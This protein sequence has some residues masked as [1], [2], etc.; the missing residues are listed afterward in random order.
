MTSIAL[1]WLLPRLSS[2]CGS[3]DHLQ[4]RLSSATG[5]EPFTEETMRFC[6]ALG[7][8]L[9]PYASGNP[10]LAA[11]AFWLR[12][13]HVEEM[14]RDLPQRPRAVVSGRG[15]VFHITPANV[16]TMFAYSL[17]VSLLAGNANVIRLSE[18]HGPD[19]ETILR[20]LADVLSTG[21]YPQVEAGTT[22]VRFGHD[23]EVMAAISRH[24]DVRVI[25]GGDRTIQRVRMVPLPAHA[26]EVTFADRES[27]T[28]LGAA[29]YESA[30]DVERD[31]VARLLANDLYAFDQMGCASP[32]R[33]VW[34]RETSDRGTVPAGR[35]ASLD[36]DLLTRL[37]AQAQPRGYVA[38][39]ATTIAKMGA[40]AGAAADGACDSVAWPSNELVVVRAP[41]PLPAPAEF[42]GGGFLWSSVCGPANDIA[43]IVSRSTQTLTAFG[44]P[45][46]D[47][48]ALAQAARC[49]GIDRITPL[50]TA[51][52][53]AP[54]WDGYDLFS[55][56]TRTTTVL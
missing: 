39:T 27:L 15:L 21:G 1:D 7:R 40:A 19:T 56:L 32:R 45:T 37:A 34:V 16:D 46:A 8:A 25:W 4:E 55:H 48:M 13:A 53:F 10:A 42:P 38:P 30:T 54:V 31:E 11:L 22:I 14:R 36:T 43:R 2:S 33:L 18:R 47:L 51:L 28:A 9:R 44:I 41:W 5:A 6:D 3:L 52:S 29:A 20:A 12:R 49:T 35:I 24:C 17:V 26:T 50:G 23:D